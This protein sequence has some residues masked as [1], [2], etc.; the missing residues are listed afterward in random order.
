LNAGVRAKASAKYA[1]YVR[2]MS[3]TDHAGT[4]TAHSL[5]SPTS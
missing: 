5:A 2:R 1:A 3:I 4:S